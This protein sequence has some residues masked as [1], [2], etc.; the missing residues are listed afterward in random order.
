MTASTGRSR[1]RVVGQPEIRDRRHDP[2]A[3]MPVGACH[4]CAH[5]I[6]T[7]PRP[8]IAALEAS[9]STPMQIMPSA[10]SAVLHQ[11]IGLPGE[12]A[13]AE[14][15]GDHLGG[16]QR[17]PGDAHTDGEAGKDVR[18]RGGEIDLAEDRRSRARLDTAPRA[19]A[20]GSTIA[21]PCSVLMQDRE[22]RAEEGD[23]DDALLV[24]RPQHDRHRH[25]GDG[26]DRAKHLGTGKMSSR[27]RR[28]RP[29]TRPSGTATTAAS[30][31]ADEDAPAAQHDVRE[32]F[33]IVE[34]PAQPARAPAPATG[35]LTKSDADVDAVFGQQV[36]GDEE[37][38]EAPERRAAMRPQPAA[39]EREPAPRE[40]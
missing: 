9:P 15:A 16:D 13:D 4:V 26:G 10:M 17:H 36:P 5:G 7:W 37:S 25:P 3:A 6:T 31:E 2:F 29:I 14:L 24:R 1:E 8:R 12:V 34:S 11:R 21:M 20:P 22:E 40:L 19:P 23:E 27:T 38:A 35:T 28:K 30:D 32:E 33:R 39:V 18:Q